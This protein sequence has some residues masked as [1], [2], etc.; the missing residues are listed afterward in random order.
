VD[1][2]PDRTFGPPTRNGRGTRDGRFVTAIGGN[3]A[4][5]SAVAIQPDGKVVVAGST[6]LSGESA[7][8][9][10]RYHADGSLDTTFDGDGKVVVRVQDTTYGRSLALQKDGKIVVAGSSYNTGIFSSWDYD[11]AVARLNPNGSLDRTFDGDGKKAVG[12]GAD[13][14]CRAVAIDY[15]GTASSNTNWGKIVLAGTHDNEDYHGYG[16]TR[17]NMNGSI[18]RTFNE[19]NAFNR[20][21][22]LIATLDPVS[23]K[24]TLNN[25]MIQRDGK[26]VL[27]GVAGNPDVYGAQQF[28]LVR[29]YSDGLF[30]RGFGDR[31]KVVTGFGGNDA[32]CDVVQSSDGG[33]IAAGTVN[34]K[35]A[36][37]GYTA[38]GRLNTGFGNGGRVQLNHGSASWYSGVGLATAPGRKLVIAGGSNFAS[39]R[40]LDNGGSLVFD[41]T[42][43]GNAIIGT[44][45]FGA[46][47]PA[48]P[49]ATQPT[50]PRASD[51]FSNNRIDALMTL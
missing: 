5:A 19:A 17:L 15:H 12:F 47:A 39:A 37:A 25:M 29:L 49:Q 16:V 7:F 4:D 46:T 6:S 42:L 3:S 40:L 9:I 38:D 22:K 20:D 14:M 44:R 23:G 32:A 36:L 35:L 30:D 13:D 34:G 28:A 50:G 41:P 24:S 45:M 26:I 21:G 27:S 10:V 11:F 2:S 43:I 18:D 8:A 1:G 33:L 31:G 48:K 51:L